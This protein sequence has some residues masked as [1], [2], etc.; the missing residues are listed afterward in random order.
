MK[1]NQSK[2]LTNL[3]TV[4][5]RRL[6]VIAT[7]SLSRVCHEGPTNSF[8]VLRRWKITTEKSADDKSNWEKAMQNYDV[9]WSKLW[10]QALQKPAFFCL[11]QKWVTTTSALQ[12][13]KRWLTKLN[14][15]HKIY[16]VIKLNMIFWILINQKKLETYI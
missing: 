4:Q 5:A 10:I 7:Y 6:I 2:N 11:F 16:L 3:Q 12:L 14:L 15:K 1:G 13:L 8:F 9:Q